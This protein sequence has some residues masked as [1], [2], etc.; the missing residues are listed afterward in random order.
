[1]KYINERKQQLVVHDAR[2]IETSEIQHIHFYYIE[3]PSFFG[4]LSSCCVFACA[5]LVLVCFCFFG[6]GIIDNGVAGI[7]ASG[8]AG[9][10]FDA[11][12]LELLLL[13]FVA[14]L[15]WSGPDLWEERVMLPQNRDK[16]HRFY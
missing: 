11:G 1:M 15:L 9:I 14:R 7:A 3:Q 12:L 10:I 6:V 16:T 5:Y 2:H 8:V 13:A 4:S